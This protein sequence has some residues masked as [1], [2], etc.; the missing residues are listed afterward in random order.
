MIVSIKKEKKLSLTIKIIMHL[1]C[2]RFRDFYFNDF[3][4]ILNLTEPEY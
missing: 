2:I 1:L 3:M 4:E